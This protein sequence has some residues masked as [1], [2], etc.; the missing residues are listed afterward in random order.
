MDATYPRCRVSRAMHIIAMHTRCIMS[1]CVCVC[2]TRVTSL[3]CRYVLGLSVMH[4]FIL[5]PLFLYVIVRLCLALAIDGDQV[6]DMRCGMAHAHHRAPGMRRCDDARCAT[7]AAERRVAVDVACAC[8][9]CAC[10]CTHSTHVLLPM[11][12]HPM[13]SDATLVSR[14]MR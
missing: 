7:R 9:R 3:S 1:A 4:V 10:P 12:S 5:L 6:T 2:C 14:C 8:G 11:S 13:N